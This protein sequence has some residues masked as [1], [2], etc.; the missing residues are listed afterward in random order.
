MTELCPSQLKTQRS[1][2]NLG[3]GLGHVLA[4]PLHLWKRAGMMYNTQQA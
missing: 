2:F 4:Q 1:A 3:H